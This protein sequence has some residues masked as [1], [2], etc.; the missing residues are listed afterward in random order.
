MRYSVRYDRYEMQQTY[1]T[2][3]YIPIL[4]ADDGHA[5]TVACIREFGPH[6]SMALEGIESDSTVP[7]RVLLGEPALRA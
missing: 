3:E 5:W 1:S 2:F 7:L 6:W 4:L